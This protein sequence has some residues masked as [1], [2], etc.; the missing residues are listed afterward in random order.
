LKHG[1]HSD[2]Y[3]WSVQQPEKT[4]FATI[5]KQ[6]LHSKGEYIGGYWALRRC[7]ESQFPPKFSA[8][9]SQFLNIHAQRVLRGILMSTIRNIAILKSICK[10]FFSSI[11]KSVPSRLNAFESSLL[12]DMRFKTAPTGS[13]YNRLTAE[14]PP[15]RKAAASPHRS[16][17]RNTMQ[18]PHTLPSA[19][20]FSCR[21][22]YG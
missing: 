16:L 20:K 12:G 9:P 8:L 10:S 17:T 13:Q 4:L 1:Y 11:I 21:Y 7:M 3:K 18:P 22:H 2:T 15:L 14:K 19:G 6:S 5:D